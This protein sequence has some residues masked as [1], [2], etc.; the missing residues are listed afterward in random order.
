MPQYRISDVAELLGVSDDTVRRWV[1]AGRLPQDEDSAGRQV[2]DGETLADFARTQTAAEGSGRVS[3]RNRLAGIVTDVAVDGL[4]A[5]VDVASDL[6]L[7][8]EE[9]RTMLA[10][11]DPPVHLVITYGSSGTFFQQITNGAPFDVFLS[12]DLSHPMKLAEAGKGV[13]G[14]VFPYAVGRLV[15]WAAK[16]SP[17]DVSKGLAV[18][19]DERVKKIAIANPGHAPV[20]QGRR[21]GDDDRRGV[22]GGERQAGAG[23]DAEFA[24]PGNA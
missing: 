6:T 11:S 5:R 4:M 19:T 16:D 23:R 21:R 2:I 1:A 9:V 12:A 18:L 17:V 7:A 13:T 8:L 20:R 22:R 3:A 10:Q 24:V 15:V 14:D